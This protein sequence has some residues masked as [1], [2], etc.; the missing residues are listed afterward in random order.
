[1]KK[2]HMW[3]YHDRIYYAEILKKLGFE[4]RAVNSY[5]EFAE[6]NKE[7]KSIIRQAAKIMTQHYGKDFTDGQ[8]EMQLNDVNMNEFRSG[9]KMKKSAWEMFK[10]L[11]E[12]DLINEEGFYN[13]HHNYFDMRKS[14]QIS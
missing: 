6:L 4:F 10:A 13:I 3:T 7:H 12:A 14:N 9:K 5:E 11:I 2:N 1:M 8:L